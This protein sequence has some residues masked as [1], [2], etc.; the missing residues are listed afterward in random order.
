MEQK[1]SMDGYLQFA[2][3][4]APLLAEQ[5]RSSGAL[6]GELSPDRA[7]AAPKSAD[8]PAD[9]S[10][11]EPSDPSAD[12]SINEAARKSDE[13]SQAEISESRIVTTLRFEGALKG[14]CCLVVAPADAQALAG[15]AGEPGSVLRGAL[16]ALIEPFAAEL[17][18]HYGTVHIH[19]QDDA[20]IP[21]GSVVMVRLSGATFDGTP[22][23]LALHADGELQRGLPR[24]ARVAAAAE[25][26]GITHG[27]LG[28]VMDVE[29]NVTLRFGQRQLS[30]RDV[31]ELS[32]GSVVEL[33]REVDEPVELILDG[34]VIARGEA[35]IVDGNYG[36]RV[37]EVLQPMGI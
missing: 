33:D 28:L 22:V 9:G 36:V 7:A 35:V 16:N 6:V 5:L 34:R 25:A 19:L 11:E 1:K 12:P 4:L 27:N 10:S 3:I 32:S 8:G 13:S 21:E 14:Q 23:S 29:L 20:E 2:G 15:E 18:A 24:L 26:S 17:F 37:T 30:L 31:M